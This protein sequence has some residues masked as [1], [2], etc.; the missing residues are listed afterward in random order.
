MKK[1]IIY[2]LLSIS[3]MKAHPHTFIDVYPTLHLNGDK[4]IK[5][6][7]KWKMDDMSSAMLIMEFDLDANGKLDANENKFVYENYFISLKEYN[8]YMDII[9]NNKITNLPIP[10]NFKAFIE[11][12]RLCYS[13]DIEKK[14]NFK[15]TKFEFYDKDF[16]VAM[17]LKK[18]FVK[19]GKREVK[20][21]G[22]DKDFYFM[23]RL[24]LE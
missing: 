4:I 8:F 9:V 10:T 6:H 16:F 14:Y 7:I 11:D 12:N 1:V 24:E 23:Y 5:T 15:N 18:E 17:M 19:A 21:T 13:F 2:L 22:E 3:F 20:I